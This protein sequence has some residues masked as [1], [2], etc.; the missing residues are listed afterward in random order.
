MSV[1]RLASRNDME[2]HLFFEISV[3]VDARVDDTVKFQS[4]CVVCLSKC[5]SAVCLT[6]RPEIRTEPNRR[7]FDP[8]DTGLFDK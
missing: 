1:G 4:R 3:K 5:L 6:G 7:L 8:R 2:G